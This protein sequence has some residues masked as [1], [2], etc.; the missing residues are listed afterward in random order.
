MRNSGKA[1]LS[2]LALAGISGLVAC[3]S[4][5]PEVQGEVTISPPTGQVWAWQSLSGSDNIEVATPEH[6]TADTA[7]A[8]TATAGRADTR[9]T[10]VA[11]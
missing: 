11:W 3:G 10:T 2:L 1:A 4:G 7:S 6:Y 8:L 9:S 5:E